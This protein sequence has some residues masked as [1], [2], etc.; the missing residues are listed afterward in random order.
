MDTNELND[1]LASLHDELTHGQQLNDESR[2]RLQVLLDDIRATLNRDPSTPATVPS[3]DHSLSD[4][5]QEALVEFEAAHPK[6]S[7]MIGR[8]A[9]GLSNLGI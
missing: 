6:L 5:L 1:T 3:A 4:R 8:I 9:D 2:E 7:Q